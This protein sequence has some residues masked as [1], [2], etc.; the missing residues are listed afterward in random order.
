MHT[1]APLPDL[2]SNTKGVPLHLALKTTSM[3]LV[4]AAC[5]DTIKVNIVTKRHIVAGNATVIRSLR[6][7]VSSR[8]M[9]LINSDHN[10]VEHV[11]GEDS[12]VHVCDGV[13]KRMSL[14]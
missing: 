9:Q 8:R 5:A 2:A 10:S 11:H 13:V 6:S 4:L 7:M 12:W 14:L 3:G 1:V